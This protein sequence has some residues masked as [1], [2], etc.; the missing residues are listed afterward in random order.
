MY[1]TYEK[2]HTDLRGKYTHSYTPNVDLNDATHTPEITTIMK[3][4]KKDRNQININA[5]QSKD[6]NQPKPPK[7][8]KIKP[9]TN[10]NLKI[11][12]IDNILL[13]INII[14]N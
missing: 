1:L 12:F 3:H 10:P 11:Q 14:I 6:R 2:H 13:Q 7:Q 4:I 8:L 5:N 9:K